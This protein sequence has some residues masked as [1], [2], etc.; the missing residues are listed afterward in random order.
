MLDY[1]YCSAARCVERI[2]Q[3]LI[4]NEQLHFELIPT[5]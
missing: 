5:P 2:A 1:P 4:K 3:N